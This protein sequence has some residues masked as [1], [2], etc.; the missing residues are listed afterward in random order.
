MP[1]TTSHAAV[2]LPLTRLLPSLPI[3]ALAIGSMSPDFEYLYNFVP[4]GRNWHSPPGLYAV[5]LPSAIAVWLVWRL[6]VRPAVMSLCP[7]GLSDRVEVGRLTLRELAVSLV[8]VVLGICSHLVWDGITHSNGWA[9]RMFYT[10]RREVMLGDMFSPPLYRL[11]Q[12]ASTVAGAMVLLAW[13]AYWWFSQP[14]EAR[15]FAPE[16]RPRLFLAAGLFFVVSLFLAAY[17][18]TRAPADLEQILSYAAVGWMVGA[19]GALL[20]WS[21]IHRLIT[22]RTP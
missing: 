12:H 22:G 2:A 13:L 20:L 6:L 17:N 10:L 5:V 15:R 7:P 11:L 9:P 8:A 14:S 1:L 4:H 19:A 18:A 21:V 3:A 16:Q